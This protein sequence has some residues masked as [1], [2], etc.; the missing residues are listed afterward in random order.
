M[1]CCVG[2][3]LYVQ[4][5]KWD[6][7]DLCFPLANSSDRSSA[8]PQLAAVLSFWQK[9]KKRHGQ[10]VRE[11]EK[12]AA[13]LAA[14]GAISNLSLN[15]VVDDHK[16]NRENDDLDKRYGASGGEYEDMMPAVPPFSDVT[17]NVALPNPGA[18]AGGWRASVAMYRAERESRARSG[19]SGRPGDQGPTSRAPAAPAVPP[20]GGG[21]EAK[22]TR[23]AVLQGTAGLT[24]AERRRR[25]EEN[26][27][28]VDPSQLQYVTADGTLC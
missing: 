24:Q 16:A 22:S 3:A 6:A 27:A 4:R 23:P 13:D 9:R 10:A 26:L 20:V 17:Q 8:L 21:S 2:I 1:F 25:I 12:H 15:H 18:G 11:M 28:S 19:S 5:H 7:Q 14:M